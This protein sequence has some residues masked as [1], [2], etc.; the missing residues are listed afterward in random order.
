MLLTEKELA[1]YLKVSKVYLYNCRIRGMPFLRLS[2]N[3]I[4]YDLDVVLL[5]FKDNN[6]T[7]NKR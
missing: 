6:S 1:S 3:C 5:W 7:F 2:R 4:R